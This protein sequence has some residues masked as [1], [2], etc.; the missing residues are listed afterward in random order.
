MRFEDV[1]IICPNCKAVMGE[2]TDPQEADE[3]N[4]TI[5]VECSSCKTVL[6]VE[7]FI[8]AKVKVHALRDE[9]PQN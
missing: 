6:D 1:K 8:T 9:L 3:D 7:F 2:E 5:I 4:M